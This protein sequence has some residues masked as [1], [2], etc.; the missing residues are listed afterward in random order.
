M[1]L[2]ALF[3]A[4]NLQTHIRRIYCVFDE[5]GRLML[6]HLSSGLARREMGISAPCRWSPFIVEINDRCLDVPTFRMNPMD[7]FEVD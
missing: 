1:G 3:F 5:L 7:G 2:Y 4:F 6:V